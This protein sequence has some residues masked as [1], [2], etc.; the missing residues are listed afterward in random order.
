MFMVGNQGLKGRVLSLWLLGHWIVLEEEKLM[1]GAE[2]DFFMEKN[3]CITFY[4][5]FF[6]FQFHIILI[7]F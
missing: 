6:C 5:V 4:F 3:I 1:I 7:C 2:K